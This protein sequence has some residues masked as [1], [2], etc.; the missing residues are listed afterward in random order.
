MISSKAERAYAELA[1]FLGNSHRCQSCG[2]EFL[3]HEDGCPNCGPYG[4]VTPIHRSIPE[5][6]EGEATHEI[7]IEISAEGNVTFTGSEVSSPKR[8]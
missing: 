8:T 1:A 2:Q 5:P 7:V 6:A 3:P 4:H